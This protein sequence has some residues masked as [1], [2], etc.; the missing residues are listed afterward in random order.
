MRGL[1]YICGCVNIHD[2]TNVT[3]N[4]FNV[5][6]SWL[7]C[8]YI[9]KKKTEIEPLTLISR[10]KNRQKKYSTSC[11]FYYFKRPLIIENQN[12]NNYCEVL[13]SCLFKKPVKISR[14]YPIPVKHEL[15]WFSWIGDISLVSDM[16]YKK[17]VFGYIF[18]IIVSFRKKKRFNFNNTW[19]HKKITVLAT[20]T[21]TC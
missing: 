5:M 12:N 6:S 3:T 11:L 10:K 15:F 14:P 18:V 20:W 17:K 4:W 19:F 8:L 13:K 2:W 1:K 21:E 7:F 9:K 16:L